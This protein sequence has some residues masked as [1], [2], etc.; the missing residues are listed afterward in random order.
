MTDTPEQ[1]EHPETVAP[2]ESSL[3]TE[4]GQAAPVT[5][6]PGAAPEAGPAASQTPATPLWKQ[7]WFLP[8]AVGAGALLVGIAVGIPI[9]AGASSGAAEASAATYF[10]DIAAECKAKSMVRVEDDGR[11]M[12]VDGEGEDAGSGDV[13]LALLDC[14]IGA[15][16]TPAAT[17][18]LMYETRSLDG[19][20]SDSWED[21]D[22]EVEASWSY[23]PDDGLDIIYEISD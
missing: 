11:T 7:P 19:R 2:Q 3:P 16:G 8:A 6:D 22:V 12:I 10:D 21:G 15:T 20:Q 1:P 23:H 13:S 9:G 14:L 4:A 18:Q 17:Q 5:A